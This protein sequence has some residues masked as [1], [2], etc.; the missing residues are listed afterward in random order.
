M[1]EQ[2]KVVADDYE[3]VLIRGSNFLGSARRIGV[4]SISV[5]GCGTLLPIEMSDLK[6]DVA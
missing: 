6:Q 3:A 4:I 5:I 2:K 1:N